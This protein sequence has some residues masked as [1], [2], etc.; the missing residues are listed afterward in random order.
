[1]V[2]NLAIVMNQ[3]AAP[4]SAHFIQYLFHCSES[5]PTQPSIVNAF[6]LGIE[7]A[8]VQTIIIMHNRN[9]NNRNHNPQ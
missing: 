5:I 1:M 8:F 3:D 2:P 9:N 6:A 7:T 4:A